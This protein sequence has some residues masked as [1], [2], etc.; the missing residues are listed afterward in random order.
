[1]SAGGVATLGEE[2]WENQRRHA[3]GGKQFA[4]T[5]LFFSGYCIISV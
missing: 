1:M 2:L 4:S 5:L 3:D